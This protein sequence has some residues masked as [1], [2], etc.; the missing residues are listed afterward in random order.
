[1][2]ISLHEK[3]WNENRMKTMKTEENNNKNKERSENIIR[4]FKF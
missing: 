3:C 2:N 1:M 4:K